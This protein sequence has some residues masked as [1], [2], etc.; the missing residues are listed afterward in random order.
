MGGLNHDET[1]GRPEVDQRGVPVHRLAEAVGENDDGQG[2][3][4]RGG[5]YPDQQIVAAAGGRENHRTGGEDGAE[6]ADGIGAGHEDPSDEVTRGGG[7]P[8]QGWPVL[9]S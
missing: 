6:Y 4:G 8:G 7:R 3:S 2:G 9:A 1:G 5:G